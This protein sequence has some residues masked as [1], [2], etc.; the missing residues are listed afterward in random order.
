VLRTTG[1]FREGGVTCSKVVPISSP[2]RCRI[3]ALLFS[4]L[5]TSLLFTVLVSVNYVIT[6]DHCLVSLFQSV[7]I[8]YVLLALDI[9]RVLYVG[10]E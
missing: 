3:C 9:H 10:I 2:Y 8:C 7:N 4:S 6:S 5:C 1:V